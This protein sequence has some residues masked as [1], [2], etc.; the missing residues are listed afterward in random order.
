MYRK[1]FASSAALGL[2]FAL[3]MTPASA[4]EPAPDAIGKVVKTVTDLIKP[5][6]VNTAVEAPPPSSDDDLPGNET[7][8]P[9]SPDHGSTKGVEVKI[10]E[11]P[12]LGLNHDN[13]TVNDDDSTS[14]DSTLLSLGGQEIIGA[15][16]SSTGDNSDFFNP[17]GPLCAGSG[18][19]LCADVLYSEA[20]ATDD[21]TTSS[22]YSRSG[23]LNACVGGSDTDS[24]NGCDG[25]VGIGAAQSE[26]GAERDQP[27][28]R[29]IAGAY[30]ETAYVC[31]TED[32]ATCDLAVDALGSFGFADSD[33]PSNTGRGSRFFSPLEIFDET[34]TDLSIPPSCPEDLSLACLFLN[35]GETY[36]APGVGGTAQDALKLTLL[37][38]EVDL[39]AGIGHT[40][41]L[42]HNDGGDVIVC[43]EN[44]DEDCS[45]EPCDE[46]SDDDCDPEPC[47]EDSDDDCDDGDD[48][49]KPGRDRALPDTGGPAAGLLALG[50]FGVAIGSSF[51]AAGR[52][53]RDAG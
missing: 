41:T 43:D 52:R 20:Y 45:P 17:L 18:G 38:G 32:P 50:L 6:N 33:N 39:F 5:K 44:G 23:V 9:S 10:G 22:S 46:D 29:T 36:L 2:F 25:Y 16:A 35:Q 21:G 19:A 27:S 28:G 47:E 34:P 13:A 1:F 40:E 26:A 42:A 12:I 48:R 14:A 51:I 31:L 53:E 8:D 11:Q 37:P 4:E 15:H 3:L 30:Y 49:D 7:Q 24:Q